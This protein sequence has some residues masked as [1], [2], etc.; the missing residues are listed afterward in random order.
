MSF[1]LFS[2]LSSSPTFIESVSPS[3]L[4]TIYQ[5]LTEYNPQVIDFK[6][7]DDRTRYAPSIVCNFCS[8]ENVRN[9]MIENDKLIQSIMLQCDSRSEERQQGVLGIIRN[10]CFDT[11]ISLRLL[12]DFSLSTS[13]LRFFG[14]N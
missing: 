11:R 5:T 14:R 7:R 6:T 8:N 1:M 9:E 3:L 4:Q 13:L 10:L 12:R 2:N